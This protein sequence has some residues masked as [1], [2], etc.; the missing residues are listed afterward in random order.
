MGLVLSMVLCGSSQALDNPPVAP[1]RPVTD[2]YFGT[3]VVDNYRYMETLTD[4]EVQGYMHSQADYT[5]AALERLPGRSALLKRIHALSSADLRRGR[6]V[7]RGAR[8]FYLVS[9]PGAQLPKLYYRDGLS[10]DDH[11]LVNPETL[12]A[13]SGTHFSLDFYTP[14]WDGR[15]V[16]YGLSQGGSEQSVLHVLEVDSGRDLPEAI[17]RTS[18]STVAWRPDNRSFFYLR[19]AKPGPDTPRSALLYNA[20]TYLHTLGTLASGDAD[21]AVFGRGVKPGLDVPEGQ[22]T[23][24]VLAADSRHAL[25]V[26]NHNA[27]SNPSTLYVAPL[28]EVRGSATPWQ[29]IA[30]VSDGVTQFI[31][32]GDTLYFLS[33]KDAPH[34]RLLATALARP[35][36]AHARVLVPEGDAVLTG[37]AADRDGLYVREREGALSHLLRVAFDGSKSRELNLPFEGSVAATVTDARES[38]ALVGLQGWTRSPR[39]VAY[40]PASDSARETGLLPASQ[41]ERADL[42]S[43]EVFAV[44]YDGTRIPLSLI[45]LKGL[46]LDHSHPTIL[47]GY[48][49]YGLSLEPVFSPARIAWIERGGVFAVAHVR[50]GGENGEAW[51]LAG[52]KLTKLNT[53]F[54]FIACGRYLVDAGYTTSKLLAGSG[55]SAG[56]ITVGGALT[57]KPDAFGV[58]LDNVGVSDGL[59][60][61]TEPNGPPNVSEFGSVSTPEGFH[62]LYAM[63]A[64]LH[65]QDGVSYPA[66]MFTTGA[67]DPRVAPWQMLKMTARVQA[68]SASGRPALLRVDFDAGHGIGSRA[69]QSEALLADEWS[70]A[71]W[72]MGDAAFQPAPGP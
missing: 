27:D 32:R 57:L 31:V 66:V 21:A 6:F 10:G 41:A 29:K 17:D 52:Q 45:Y 19:Y 72:Q 42:E 55:G 9:E 11:L 48:G 51:H 34:F 2:R 63:S 12:G 20:R 15:L 7:R 67:N 39:L 26:A 24:I 3:D 70:F 71:L 49:S 16:A 59:R 54:D 60:M 61:E 4:P 43:R 38:G 25:A 69:S 28:G 58:I 18:N 50:G 1:V 47:Q 36:V 23:Y 35:D 22:V 40:D 53:V 46:K 5:R 30:D 68:A 33:Q 65:V 8:Y 37:L 62:G 44:G 56:G 14:S 13:G 64:Y